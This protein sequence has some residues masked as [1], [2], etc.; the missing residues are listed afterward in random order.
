MTA[1][2]VGGQGRTA[3]V[4]GTLRTGG[5]LVANVNGPNITCQ[6]INV[7][8]LVRPPAAVDMPAERGFA[9]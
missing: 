2:E 3:T 1:V 8:S 6:G 7:S 9:K 4:D 5:W